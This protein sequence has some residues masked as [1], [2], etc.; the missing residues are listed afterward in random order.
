MTALRQA[1]ESRRTK[2]H[3]VAWKGVITFGVDQAPVACVIK[4]ISPVGVQVLIG[5]NSRVPDRFF[6]KLPNGS[7]S[8][9]CQVIW[10]DGQFLGIKFVGT[11]PRW[12]HG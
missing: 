3:N 7:K 11:S 6:L 12:Q 5:P 4:D 1:P 9:R 10:R 8:F 2:R